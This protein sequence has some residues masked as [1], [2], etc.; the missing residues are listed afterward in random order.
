MKKIIFTVSNDLNTDQRMQRI[1]S[2]LCDE[3]FDV[4]IIGRKKKSSNALLPQ[5]FRQ[6]RLSLFFEKGKLFYIEL[7]CRLFIYLLFQKF[8]VV[9]GIDLDTIMPC[10][11]VSKIRGKKCVYDA[12]ELFSEVP[13]LTR[14]PAIRKLWLY[15]ERFI[16]TK[17]SI[18]KYTVSQSVADEFK[19]RYNADF[20]VVRNFPIQKNIHANST[21]HKILYRGAVNEGRGLE[22]LIQAMVDIPAQLI[23]AGGGDVLQQLKQLSNECDVS[24]K[25]TFTGYLNPD[26]LD[27]ISQQASIGVNLLEQ[28]SKNYYYSLANKFFD[29]VQLHLPQVCMNFPEYKRMNE[30]HEVALLVDS[31]DSKNIAYSLNRLLSDNTLYD[32]LRSGCLVASKEWIWCVEKKNLIDIYKQL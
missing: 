6:K 19:S 21:E 4:L 2:T 28:Y 16:C 17:T 26:E 11:M 25:I 8:D 20:K 27:K 30:Q 9:C 12:H 24:Y 5:P 10:Y 22:A 1:C 15:L 14:R 7:Q 29:Y 18:V 31:I 13:E 23:I 3:G 32:K